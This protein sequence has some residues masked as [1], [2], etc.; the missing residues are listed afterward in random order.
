MGTELVCLPLPRCLCL[1]LFFL[2]LLS[3]Q[4]SLQFPLAPVLEVIGERRQQKK[5]G[6]ATTEEV[7]AP[8]SQTPVLMTDP[9]KVW[10]EPVIMTPM[11]ISFIRPEAGIAGTS[12][13]GAGSVAVE[14]NQEPNL[15]Q[16]LLLDHLLGRL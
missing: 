12:A 2:P 13:V 11:G 3:S 1:S 15:D 9:C 8:V 7:V 16:G 4:L 14:A 6:S 5:I 10:Q